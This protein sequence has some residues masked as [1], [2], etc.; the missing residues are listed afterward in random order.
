MKTILFTLF[1]RLHQLWAGTEEHNSQRVLESVLPVAS[2][3][4]VDV[5]N[6]AP[7]WFRDQTAR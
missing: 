5:A 2:L 6:I 4:G 7:E 1:Q 3:Y